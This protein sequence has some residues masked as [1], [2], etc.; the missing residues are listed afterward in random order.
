MDARALDEFETLFEQA[1]EPAV[2]IEPVSWQT[3]LVG[4]DGSPRSEA[5]LAAGLALARREQLPLRLLAPVPPGEAREPRERQLRAALK[6]AEEAGV[7]AEGA[8]AEGAP[9]ALLIAALESCSLLALPAPFGSPPQADSLG[10]VIDSV[11]TATDTPLLL[12]KQALPAPER[13]FARLIV[14]VP[15]GFEVGPHFSIPFALVAPDG[16][17]DLVHIVDSAQIAHVAAALELGGT[18]P[19]EL[20]RGLEQ[21]MQKLLGQAVERV[22]GASYE[23]RS[24]V[25]SG[26]PLAWLA[27]HLL[28]E[29]A[30]LLVVD[31]ET[32]KGVPVPAESYAVIKQVAGVPILVL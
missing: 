9:A 8:C 32:R 5:A 21:R 2:A 29:R 16:V 1:V 20:Q 10:T 11:L 7:A 27:L 25:V 15:D 14:Y 24:R 12:C 18:T 4:L 26:E 31:S 19:E 23:A 17:L 3:V 28:N 30:S 22:S 6:T 13:L